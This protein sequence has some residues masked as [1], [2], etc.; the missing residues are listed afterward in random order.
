MHACL[1]LSPSPLLCGAPPPTSLIHVHAKPS[2]VHVCA[3]THARVHTCTHMFTCTCACRAFPPPSVWS[4]FPCPCVDPSPLPVHLF[5]SLRGGLF[6]TSPRGAF[7]PSLRV[8]L[9]TLLPCGAFPPP[10]KCVHVHGFMSVG[11]HA[12]VYTTHTCTCTCTHTHVYMHSH[13]SP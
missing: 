13:Q 11:M 9:F 8:E 3:C 2:L 1:E 7:F 4:S 6:Q 5:P 12:C 10:C